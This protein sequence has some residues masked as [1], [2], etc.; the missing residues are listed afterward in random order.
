MNTGECLCG[1]IKFK[2]DGYQ[3]DIYRCH[4][5]KCRRAGGANSN[6][7]VM[8]AQVDFTWIAGQD[9]LTIYQTDTVYQTVF[10]KVCGSPMPQLIASQ[11]AYYVPAGTL[12]SDNNLRLGQSVNIDSRAD[13]DTTATGR[14]TENNGESE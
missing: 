12:Q 1:A 11:D 8:V 14:S 6:A 3:G 9:G 13:W 5:S 4:C 2:V 10:C 7:A